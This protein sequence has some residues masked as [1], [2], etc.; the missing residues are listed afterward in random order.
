MDV[1]PGLESGENQG[2]VCKLLKSLY[3]LK[4]SPRA[5]FD[6]LTQVLK[7]HGF[8]QG[9]TDHTM[10][11]K[12]SSDG[13][14]VVMIIYVDDII[15]TGDLFREITRLKI[16]MEVARS[17][18]GIVV[19]QRK[20][21]LDLLSETGLLGCKP[22]S[23]PM[24]PTSKSSQPKEDAELVDKGRYQRLVGKLIYLT[25]TRPDIGYA[26]GM[27]SRFMNTPTKQNMDAGYGLFFK[28]TNQRDLQIFTDADWGGSRTDG[29]STTGYCTFVWGNL[30]T[31][32]SKKQQ[33]VARSSTEA[34]FKAMCHGICEG[35]WV[36]RMLKELKLLNRTNKALMRQQGSHRNCKK[37]GASR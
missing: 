14:I 24:E 13:R 10:F 26:V 37:S 35:I 22:T 28:K 30:V 34:E 19:S 27:V 15:I 16:G 29:R 33:V 36:K 18:Q 11:T 20:Y 8:S 6:R 32:R 4:Q 9:Q 21:T 12:H 31:W 1:P 17:K 3:G 5:W 7:R 2:K 25:H 23:I